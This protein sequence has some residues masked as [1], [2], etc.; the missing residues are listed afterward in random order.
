MK[1]IVAV[2]VLI[3][4]EQIMSNTSGYVS[5]AAAFLIMFCAVYLIYKVY[6][7]VFG[8][9][10]KSDAQPSIT[11]KTPEFKYER[12]PVIHAEGSTQIVRQERVGFEKWKVV[13]GSFGKN[14]QRNEIGST[15]IT[16]S[17]QV[18]SSGKDNFAV[19][20]A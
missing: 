14:G 15:T 10:T 17:M 16:P 5:D 7:F 2:L 13:M 8:N 3:G 11:T 9:S 12:R 4:A 19:T 1:F 20:W 6:T 18:F